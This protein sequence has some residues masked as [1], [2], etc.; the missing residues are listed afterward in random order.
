MPQII[1]KKQI[2][3]KVTL[4]GDPLVCIQVMM[5]SP[6]PKVLLGSQK[7]EKHC[8]KKPSLTVRCLIAPTI[9]HL[10]GKYLMGLTPDLL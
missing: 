2:F 5:Q 1:F 9:S 6:L 8:E 7:E 10:V 4:F 3:S